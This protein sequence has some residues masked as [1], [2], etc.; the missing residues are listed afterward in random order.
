MKNIGAGGTPAIDKIATKDNTFKEAMLVIDCKELK[1][2][3]FFKLKLN[4]IKAKFK[5][6]IK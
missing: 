6:E 1:K 2:I 5:K 3:K 4:K